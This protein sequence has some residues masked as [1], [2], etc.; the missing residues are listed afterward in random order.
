MP[1]QETK[2]R[3][4]CLSFYPEAGPSVRHRIAGYKKYWAQDRVELTIAPFLTKRLFRN[5]RKFGA[6]NQT[7]KMATLLFCVVRALARLPRLPFYDA[8]IIHREIFPFGSAWYERLVTRLNPR[9]VFDFDDAIWV[10]M[11]LKINQRKFLWDP[12]KVADTIQSC[13]A[14]VAGNNYLKNYAVS[15]NNNCEV[16][17][18]PYPDIGGGQQRITNKISPPII[19]WI[20]NVGNDEYL[21][22]IREPLKKLAT[23]HDFI[24]R[25]IGAPSSANYQIE[26]VKVENLIWEM[27]QEANWL[28]ESSIGV[29]PLPDREYEQGK[30]AFKIVQYYSAGLP[31]VA[32]P[33]GMNCDVV[34]P[35]ETGYLADSPAQW[36]E[37]LTLL[38]DDD[39]HR[40][41]LSAAAHHF[42]QRYFQP[43]RLAQQ[44]L[45][46]LRKL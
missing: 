38:L 27:N 6:W 20:G 31:V 28:L 39:H 10:M 25:I 24:F 16:I 32:S 18:T 22:P 13:A 44:W 14:V 42:H 4:L 19:V 36:L 1:G 15:F 35:G 46:L 3:V 29:M 26:G 23:T 9:C 17:P 45:T 33:V 34:D 43:D 11:P 41:Q 5:R 8:I 37:A 40:Q 2:M 12:N 7:I 30:C 21:E